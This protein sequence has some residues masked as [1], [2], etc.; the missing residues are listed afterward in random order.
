MD[1]RLTELGIRHMVYGRIK[2]PYSIYRKMCTSK[3]RPS[4]PMTVVWRDW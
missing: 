1:D 2:H 3:G 4:G